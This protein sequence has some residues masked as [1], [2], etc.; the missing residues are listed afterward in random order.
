MQ[1]PM[2]KPGSVRR[3]KGQ[4]ESMTV[5]L[6]CF[7][8][9]FFF[10][11]GRNWWVSLGLD[12]LNNSGRLWATGVILSYLGCFRADEYWLSVREFDKWGVWEHGLW[13]D[14]LYVKGVLTGELFVISRNW[15][16][17]GSR[18]QMPEHQEYRKTVSIV[19]TTGS[20]VLGVITSQEGSLYMYLAPYSQL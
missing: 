17:L 19:N 6:Y 16:A 4:R 13:T 7:F 1:G 12:S 20:M 5:S 10:F 8:V 14:W 2:G 15:L 9:C 18:P 3:Q 11:A